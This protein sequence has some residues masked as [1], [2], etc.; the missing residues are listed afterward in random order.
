MEMQIAAMSMSMA[1]ANAQNALAIG[2]MRKTMDSQEQS[3][4]FIT[5]MLDNMPSPDGRGQILDLRA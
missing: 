4:E 5:E 1:S 3:M 2:M